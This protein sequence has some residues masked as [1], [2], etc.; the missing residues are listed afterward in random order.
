[1]HKAL[2]YLYLLFFFALIGCNDN[3]KSPFEPWQLI[4]LETTHILSLNNAPIV[5]QNK[6][7]FRD[8]TAIFS[9]PKWPSIIDSLVSQFKPEPGSLLLINQP[10]Q[11]S[12]LSDSVKLEYVLIL[13][14]EE[15]THPRLP[16]EIILGADTTFVFSKNQYSLFSNKNSLDFEPQ[17]PDKK[18]IN[19]LAKMFELKKDKPL[20]V[21]KR[22]EE[23]LGKI[24]LKHDSWVIFEPQSGSVDQSAHGV[25]LRS[26]IS[27]VPGQKSTLS[28]YDLGQNPGLIKSPEIV[29]LYANSCV[30]LSLNNPQSLLSRIRAVDSM[31]VLSPLIESIDEVSLIEF[32]SSRSLA[33][34]SLDL[35]ISLSA[36]TQNWTGEAN[37]R[38]VSIQSFEPQS[39]SLNPIPLIFDEIPQMSHVFVWEDFLILTQSLD[40]A[41][42]Y[43]IQLQNKNILAQSSA[44]QGSEEDM[45]RESNLYSWTIDAQNK[46]VETIQLIEDRGF[47]HINYSMQSG[48][49]KVNNEGQGP[50]LRSIMLEAPVAK[51]PKFFS[52]H[53]SGGKNIVVQDE[54]HRLYFLAPSG[55]T[56]W[57]RDL[58]EP[59]LGEVQEVD[60]LR[61]GKKQLAFATAS[62]W[63]VID[64]N[65]RDVTLFPK[66]F[67]DPITQ[68]LAIFD[69]DNNRK[70]RFVITQGRTVLMYDAQGKRVKGFSYNK[71][72]AAVSHPPT[73]IRINTKDYLL[74][75]LENGQLQI[76]N[77]TGKV[78]IPISEQFDF[79]SEVPIKHE[80][81]IVFWTQKGSQIQ[82]SPEGSVVKLT[83]KSPAQ[84]RLVFYGPHTVEF[85]DPLLRID[86]HFIELPLGN[87]LGPQVFKFG[88]KL[89]TVMID[90]DTQNIFVY[91]SEGRL[92]KNL[93]FFGRSM[94][95]I[96]DTNSNGKLELVTQGQDN[97]VLIYNLN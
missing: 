35:N 69:Y 80:G 56:I 78:R 79:G 7:K 30:S 68:P 90:Q 9:L 46:Q 29:P 3:R 89:R 12:A 51:A 19:A 17:Q 6:D 88:N 41:K 81:K 2:F 28:T 85:D 63:Y 58:K 31:F 50:L 76:L 77:R 84:Y 70:Y 71:A 36:L 20:L 27:T 38:G 10:Q 83:A 53:K 72:P 11:N 55:K 26:E 54:N 42:E 62:K 47:A 73:H 21:A 92:L 37:F 43:I 1:M 74:F 33:L 18:V 22:F 48:G 95:D 13:A 40:L 65:G 64:R 82:I 34:K 45:A 96:A 49:Q 32:T 67:K 94:V 39:H 86:Q 57:Y 97:E 16:K 91:N 66:S 75:L 93:P 87:Y 25:V 8:D 14:F 24:S 60:I 4:G 61:N 5:L 44:W 52:N 15:A 23:K 59:V